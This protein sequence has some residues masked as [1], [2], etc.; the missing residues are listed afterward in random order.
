[1][2]A[3]GPYLA[4]AIAL[5]AAVIAWAQWHTARSKL[6]LDL[7]NHRMDV[8]TGVSKVMARVM[9]HGT[10]DT[11][12]IVNFSGP[13]DQAR[14]LFGDDV[15][16][17][18]QELRKTL[19]NLGYCRSIMEQLKGDEEYQKAVELNYKSMLRVG[20]FYEEFG[21]LLKPYMR[22]DHKRPFAWF[23]SARRPLQ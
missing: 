4:S 18:L 22:M 6:V 16:N 1:M 20:N 8:Y 5:L 7:F 10:A 3:L 12:D 11:E 23:L 15:N 9:R 2:T 21:A 13:Q 14:F 17:Y 19:A